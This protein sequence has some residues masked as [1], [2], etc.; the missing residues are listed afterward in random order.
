MLG[1]DWRPP[2]SA[3]VLTEPR[4]GVP[5]VQGEGTVTRITG[6][7]SWS[8]TPPPSRC[9]HW[10]SHVPRMK[11]PSPKSVLPGS[12]GASAWLESHL[13][14]SRNGH[15]APSVRQAFTGRGARKAEMA[16]QGPGPRGAYIQSTR[17]TRRS[18]TRTCLRPLLRSPTRQA[19]PQNTQGKAHPAC[20][21][22]P[23]QCPCP[24]TEHSTHAHGIS[25]NQDAQYRER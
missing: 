8:R 21:S 25:K 3:P 22:T 16:R 15:G 4:S 12:L 10:V 14:H 23:G 17:W 11:V 24:A 20:P 2:W 6:T 18:K 1:H 13:V 5:T 19:A 9:S 7:P